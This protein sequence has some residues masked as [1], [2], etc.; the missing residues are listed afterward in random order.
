MMCYPLAIHVF[1]RMNIVG[2][3]QACHF[4]HQNMGAVDAM[5]K[6]STE[7]DAFVRDL[8]AKTLAA[9]KDTD[10]SDQYKRFTDILKYDPTNDNTYVPGLWDGTP[11]MGKTNAYYSQTMQE[12]KAHTIA[13]V[14]NMQTEQQKGLSTFEDF[15]KRLHE[16]WNAIKHENFVL[17]FKNVLAVEA[18]NKLSRVLDQ[19]QW[20]IK[21][22][23]RE[24]IQEEVNIIEN[25][26][27]EGNS[28]RTVKQMASASLHKLTTCLEEKI[29]KMEEDVMHY[30]QCTGCK[31]CD[32]D[33]QN[34][35]LLINNEKEFEDEVR[36]IKRSLTREMEETMENVEIKMTTDEHINK[37]SAEVDN[38]LDKKVQEA[39][40]AR[41]SENLDTKDIERTFIALW[42]EATRDI[43]ALKYIEKDPDI[44]AIVQATIKKILGRDDHYDRQKRVTMNPRMGKQNFNIDGDHMQPRGHFP[45]VQK[46]FGFSFNEQDFHRLQLHTEKIVEETTKFYDGKYFPDGKQFCRKDV[47]MLFKDVKE[48]I[49][50]IHDERFKVTKEYEM[51][52]MC[53]IEKQAVEGFTMMHRK[54][55]QSNN[56]KGLLEKKKKSFHDLLVIKMGQGNAAAKFCETVLKDVILKNIEERLSCTELLH[57]LGVHCGDIFRDIKSIHASIMV[58]LIREND[59]SKYLAYITNYEKYVKF[60]SDKESFRHFAEKNR[61]KE[62]GRTKLDQ[63]I[64]KILEA[65]E[66]TVDCS[67]HDASFIKT[68]FRKIDHLKISHDDAAGYRELDVADKEGFSGI[69]QQQLNGT[70]RED[71]LKE[72]HSWDVLSKLKKKNLTDFLF[73]EVVGCKA[74]CPFC[75][76]PCDAHSGGKTQGNHS[77]TMHRPKGLGGTWWYDTKK[78]VTLDCCLAIAAGNFF[79]RDNVWYPC[80]DY[81]QFY[82]DWTIYGNADPDVEKYWKWVF[83]QHNEKFA[84]YYSLE[85][86]DMPA[87]WGQ[88]TNNDIKKDIEDSYHVQVDI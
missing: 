9:A 14:A 11:P 1:L 72:I 3:K 54:Y 8:N 46:L 23:I 10:K 44:E 69:I 40:A 27:K 67:S 60:E 28:Q 32:N 80:G 34:R 64:T 61:L 86:A 55:Y 75:K 77:S 56:P 81:H 37:L 41:K 47:E 7:I 48:R 53:Y 5:T 36:A 35:H 15:A 26:V 39:I 25:K 71:I 31:D 65:V 4:V 88:Y 78:L 87:E 74:R 2:E 17:S 20:T 58:N 29:T 13:T 57:D 76:V 42:N 6:I 85:P 84:K 33:V 49:E 50:S 52:L 66:K 12:L 73:T 22:E 45:G 18:H 59:E 16:V 30:F 19:E 24:L 68:F 21:R 79:L 70:V 43:M 38:I 83:A 62:L 63:L 82:P 51:G